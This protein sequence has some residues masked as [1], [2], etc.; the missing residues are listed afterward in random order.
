[1][2]TKPLFQDT[3]LL[4]P[5]QIAIMAEMS[6]PTIYLWLEKSHPENPVVING[7]RVLY[8][9]VDVKV[10]LDKKLEKKRARALLQENART[11]RRISRQII[12]LRETDSQR[13]LAVIALLD[14]KNE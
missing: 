13:Y 11:I 9:A 1:M 6:Q 14:G 3:D 2:E 12:N 7:T 8:R 10:W 5:K 4:S